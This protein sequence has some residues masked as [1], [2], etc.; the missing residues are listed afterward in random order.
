MFSRK[1]RCSLNAYS[2]AVLIVSM[3]KYR[4]DYKPCTSPLKPSEDQYTSP[5][6]RRT[7]SSILKAAESWLVSATTGKKDPRKGE[8]QGV[9]ALYE[10]RGEKAISK[11]GDAFFFFAKDD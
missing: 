9:N 8:A 1:F 7:S 5:V 2:Q 11:L 3:V 4:S 10:S 6:A